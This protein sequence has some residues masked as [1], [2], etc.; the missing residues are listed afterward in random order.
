MLWVC[1]HS[2]TEVCGN[3]Q[4]GNQ[5][6]LSKRRAPSDR[7]GRSQLFKREKEGSFF[8]RGCIKLK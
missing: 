3:P 6:R 4:E 2:S 5:D 8:A 1:R 7:K